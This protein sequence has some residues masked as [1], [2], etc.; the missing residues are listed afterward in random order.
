[1]SA[2]VGDRV[3]SL[4]ERDTQFGCVGIQVVAAGV[5]PAAVVDPVY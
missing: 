2:V 1:M 3:G 4:S 5:Q